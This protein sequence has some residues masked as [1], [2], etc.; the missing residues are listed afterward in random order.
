MPLKH[1]YAVLKGTVIGSKPATSQNAHFSVRIVDDEANYRIAV[2]VKSKYH[3]HDLECHLDDDFRHP[4]TQALRNLRRGMRV[5]P[6]DWKKRR[7]DG[8]A[9]D[10]VRMNLFAREKMRPVPM[11]APGPF[12]DLNEVIGNLLH[13]AASDEGNYLCAFGEPWGP[14]TV[15]DKVFGFLPGRGIHDIHMNQGNLKAAHAHED[16]LYQDGALI[17]YLAPQDRFVAYFTK[18]Q[19]Q[20]WHTDEEG[21]HAIGRDGGR[22]EPRPGDAVAAPP[23]LPATVRIVAAMVNPAGPDEGKEYVTLANVTG[24]DIDLAGWSLLDRMDRPLKLSGV[25]SRVAP[26]TVTVPAD[27]PFKLGNNGGTITLLN[28]AGLTVHGVAYTAAQASHAGAAITFS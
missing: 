1:G 28:A 17:V 5:L 18:F 11:A 26:M 4:V 8:V 23:P 16:G 15:P 10:F 13:Q 9:L 6:A 22:I 2:N 24:A 3:P 20:S 25:L 27:A 7:E 19:S 14:E 21:G 12:D